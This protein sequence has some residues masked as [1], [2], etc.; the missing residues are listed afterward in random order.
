[1]SFSSSLILKKMKSWI[2]IQLRSLHLGQIQ[3]QDQHHLVQL[4]D[5]LQVFCPLLN[6]SFQLLVVA[7]ERLLQFQLADGT[8]DPFG[9]GLGQVVLLL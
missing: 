4:L 8:A 2:H 7:L 1:M 3:T 5:L 9:K 6:I